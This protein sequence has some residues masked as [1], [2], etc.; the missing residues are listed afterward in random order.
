MYKDKPY[1][2]PR[3]TA[4]S[5]AGKRIL[6]IFF[7]LFAIAFLYVFWGTWRSP[8]TIVSAGGTEED[9]WKWVQNLD[10]EESKTSKKIDWEDRRRKVKDV[11]VV[12]WDNYEKYGWG[13]CIH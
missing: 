4:P 6:Y 2:Q 3:R 9:L 7:G 1:F 12:S 8:R 11:F 5:R 10:A 13:R